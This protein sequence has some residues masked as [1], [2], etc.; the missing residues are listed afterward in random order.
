[1]AK[2]KMKLK[3]IKC[4][5][6]VICIIVSLCTLTVMYLGISAYFMNRFYLGSTINCINV[7]GKTVKEVDEQISSKVETYV[8]ELKER[9]EQKEQISADAIVLKYNS[10]GQV[11]EIKGRQN[12]FKWIAATFYE[13]DSK[14]ENTISY[15]E[16]LLKDQIDKLSCLN[17]NNIIAPKNASIKYTDTGYVISDEIK[18]NKIN[19]DILYDN[20][21]KA[22]LQG[23]TS[24]DLDTIKCYENPKYTSTSQEIIDAKDT[25]NK[26][27]SSKITYAFGSRTEV[28]DGSTINNWL[29]VDENLGITFDEVKVKGYLST[30]SKTYNTV[31]KTREFIASLGTTV[32]V[33]GGDYGWMINSTK[34]VQELIKVIKEGQ[35]TTKEPIYMQT[36]STRDGNDLGKTYVEVDMTKQHLWFYKNGSLVV[37]GDVVTGNVSDK[38]ATPTGVY[39]LK[40]KQKDAT[41]RGDNYNTPVSFW[42]PFNGD[43]GI[44]DAT[45]RDTFGGNIYMTNGSH[46]CVNAPYNVAKTIF[47]NIE[48]DT[49]VICYFE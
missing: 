20:V 17:S 2:L 26:Y 35:V 16:K 3:E 15:D 13:K 23:E 19:K 36:A 9:G 12:P 42:M 5:K 6:A 34:E 39:K 30:L 33:S 7:S 22:I 28:L 49:P 10:N 11:Q 32:K 44:H 48:Q 21:V 25:L 43:I 18:G 4:K 24:L 27:I 40:Y 45:W 29:K 8:L 14:M 41:L 47:S 37:D 38:N 1:M 46:G 31:G